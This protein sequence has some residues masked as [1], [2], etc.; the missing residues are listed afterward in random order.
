[1]AHANAELI[2]LRLNHAPSVGIPKNQSLKKYHRLI[3]PHDRK[4]QLT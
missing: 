1:M 3:R 4:L 2:M